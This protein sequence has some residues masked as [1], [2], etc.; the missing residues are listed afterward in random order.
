VIGL[1]GRDWELGE[2]RTVLQDM[3]TGQPRIVALRGDA[4]IGKTSLARAVAQD[5]QATGA[6]TLWAAAVTDDGAPP[7][8]L[9]RTLLTTHVQRTDPLALAAQIGDGGAELARLV[10]ELRRRLPGLSL[11]PRRAESG[12]YPLFQAVARM[13]GTMARSQPLVVVL[14]DL[15]AADTDSL[16]LLEFLADE[17]S[18]GSL[19]LVVTVRS[20]TS[21]RSPRL[22]HTI[23]AL[24][25]RPHARLLQLDGLARRDVGRLVESVAGRPV[26]AA[27]VETIHR[28]TEGNPFF[29]TELIRL[30][31]A[32]GRL[33]EHAVPL[34]GDETIPPGVEAVVAGRLAGLGEQCRAALRTGAVIGRSFA[35][36]PLADLLGEPEG[37]V[38]AAIEEAM[39]AGLLREAT[40]G[41]RFVFSHPLVHEVVVGSLARARRTRLHRQIA[42]R[43]EGSDSPSLA[44]LAH[45][46]CAAAASDAADQS[47]RDRALRYAAAAATQAMSAGAFAEA[48]VLYERAIALTGSGPRGTGA[49]RGELLVGLGH[50]RRQAGDAATARRAFLGAAAIGRE[51][52]DPRLLG[53]A[54]LGLGGVWDPATVVDEELRAL[55]DEA[56]AHGEDL[57][58][59][60]R[61]ELQARLARALEDTA[62]AR[63]AVAAARALG[64][65]RALLTAL[66][67]LHCADERLTADRRL[68]MTEEI[69]ALAARVAD[70]ERTVQAGLMLA[71]SHLERADRAAA[72]RATRQAVGDAAG[73]HRPQYES[74]P[75]VIELAWSFLDGRFA[76]V[77][78]IAGS[79]PIAE[80]PTDDPLGLGLANIY[81]VAV[82]REQGR[83]AEL[84]PLLDVVAAYPN[85]PAVRFALPALYLGSGRIEEALATFAATT[86][87]SST[88][89]WGLALMAEVCVELADR[90]RAVEIYGLLRRHEGRAMVVS[91]SLLC[92]GPADRQLGLLA[93]LLGR[94]ED[95]VSHFETALEVGRR[96]GARPALARIRLD[97][98]GVLLAR[99]RPDDRARARQLLSSARAEA[100]QLGMAAVHAVAAELQAR[101]L[102]LLAD[103]SEPAEPSSLTQRELEVL[104]LVARGLAN[105]Q[106][107]RTL[108]VSDKTVKTHV[109]NILAKVG[110]ADRTQAAI[111]AMRRGLVADR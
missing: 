100:T 88:P 79:A 99:G 91:S 85:Y 80:R 104:Q 2:L 90:A 46:W 51:R 68:S 110:A 30:L 71:R 17:V 50:A 25:R 35:L 8:W 59:E 48:A 33:D 70:H 107:A 41:D 105:K 98:A 97:L 86:V 37:P 108:E 92:L 20:A 87:Q 32:R 55:L 72:L 13:V 21:G 67:A 83:L 26:P 54:A 84:G 77:E 74:L 43:I 93:G 15:Q 24:L 23:A 36:K 11:L 47:D 5:A 57:E 19:L 14:D 34:G 61:I 27:A 95:A 64:R 9:W 75:A 81:L 78:R 76:D 28:R 6:Q 96:L 45:H 94:V 49:R 65:P 29:V 73:G 3:R 18:D 12:R 10:P 69:V 66:V 22:P 39:A 63:Q 89:P 16:L 60:Q 102:H 101:H 38:L 109:S 44:E 56:L 40:R 52:R 82:R 4:G 106:I 103:R 42:E 7:F 53:R 58:P 62:L 31:A 1:V 111:Y